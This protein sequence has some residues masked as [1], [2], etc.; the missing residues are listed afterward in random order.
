MH[1]TRRA[2]HG[3]GL[4]H[5]GT[6]GHLVARLVEVWLRTLQIL[7][8]LLRRPEYLRILG[9]GGRHT[10][11]RSKPSH[12]WPA[13]SL[14]VRPSAHLAVAG[15]GALALGMYTWP[16]ANRTGSNSPIPFLP[17]RDLAP[18]LERRTVAQISDVH[19]GPRVDDA[20]LIKS[21]R[22]G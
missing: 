18:T 22:A 21:F 1:L 20:Y 4:R 19:V 8:L 6:P 2:G 14:D 16:R 9:L 12:P 10:K 13:S 17:V 11:T 3:Y 15:S 5:T 7:S